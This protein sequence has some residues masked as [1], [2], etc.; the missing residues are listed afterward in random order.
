MKIFFF[1]YK[2]PVPLVGF[3]VQMT[4]VVKNLL[5]PAL[6]ETQTRFEL[7]DRETDRE[8]KLLFAGKFL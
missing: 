3:L 2:P 4:F 1:F 5:Y 8:K 6:P 7:K